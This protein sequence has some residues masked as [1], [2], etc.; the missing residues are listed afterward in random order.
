MF[1]VAGA[2]R[3]TACAADGQP[4]GSPRVGQ[5][6]STE[7]PGRAA[8]R[9]TP[10]PDAGRVLEAPRLLDARERGPGPSG[11]LAGACASRKL[12]HARWSVSTPSG[13]LTFRARA[14]RRAKP[15]I[16][17]V[18]ARAVALAAWRTGPV[19][20][21]AA[22]ACAGRRLPGFRPAGGGRAPRRRPD[23]FSAFAAAD[24][25]GARA[26]ERPLC[27]F[28][29]WMRRSASAAISSTTRVTSLARRRIPSSLSSHKAV[30]PGSTRTG[31]ARLRRVDC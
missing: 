12:R 15:I 29:T 7:W 31:A 24:D 30:V 18:G 26:I 3:T 25:P 8:S 17:A 6:A 22:P 5:G 2:E 1:L 4:S 27:C 9:P 11:V 16:F 21:G 10:S 28:R 23:C 19:S 20:S 14:R 13:R